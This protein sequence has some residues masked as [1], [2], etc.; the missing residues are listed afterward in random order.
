MS[1]LR[2]E[3]DA[4]HS[5]FFRDWTTASERNWRALE[6]STVYKESYRRLTAIQAIKA[7]LVGS[8]Y[9]PGSAAFFFEAHNDALVSHVS[10]SVGAWRSALQSLRSCIENSLCAV[11]YNVH[12]IELELWA[13]GEFWIGFSELIKFAEKHPRLSHLGAEVT[14]LRALR[15]EYAMLSKA[16]HGSAIDFRMTDSIS[17]VLLWSAD[18]VKA[19]MWSTREKRTL[20]GISLLLVCLHSS[21]LQGASL[22]PLRNVLHFSIGP[23]RRK[24]LKTTLRINVPDA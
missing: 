17:N 24:Q 14:G 13:A 11:Y 16:V 21:S 22:T 3:V 23:S 12:P 5:A 20:E 8:Q 1:Q 19:A 4:N 10:A 15:A 7:H 2:N 6:K 18:P 9:T